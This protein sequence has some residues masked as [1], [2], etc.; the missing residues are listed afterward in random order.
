MTEGLGDGPTTRLGMP[1]VG[2]VHLILFA[3]VYGLQGVVFAYVINFNQLYMKAS[4]LEETTINDVQTF[5]IILPFALKFLFGPISDRFNPLGLG[6]RRPFIGFG[7]LMQSL[8]LIGLALIN[9]GQH[10]G[11]FAAVALITVLGLAIYD[12]CCDGLIVDVTPE[13]D[14]P[15]VQSIV[16]VARFVAATIMTFAF[17]HFLSETGIGPGKS[18]WILYTC[19]ALGLPPLALTLVIRERREGH[20]GDQFDWHAL[21]VLIRPKGLALI[22]FGLLYALPGWGVEINL[23]LFYASSGFD[24]SDVGLCGA[25]RLSGRAVGAI[26][27][28]LATPILGRKGTI[29]LGVVGLIGSTMAHAVISVGDVATA[30]GLGFLFGVA[31]GWNDVLFATLAMGAADPRLA[32]STFALFMAVTNLNILGGSLFGR[33]LVALDGSYP[34]LFLLAGLMMLPALLLVG[35]LARLAPR[36]SDA[37]DRPD[38]FLA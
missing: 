28:P 35:P 18:G 4:G 36:A 22:A 7:I 15:R 27:L 33:G 24:E 34:P 23:P 14:R 19:A 1:R 25:A 37:K 8:G 6:H 2:R 3:L 38:E 32:A 17:G 10:V 16:M 11:G 9:P 29:L 12:T 20:P 30:A 13:A 26:L 5:A 31:N 21:K